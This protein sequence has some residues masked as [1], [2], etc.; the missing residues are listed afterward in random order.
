MGGLRSVRARYLTA[1]YALGYTGEAYF[2]S[3]NG[4]LKDLA[5]E[6]ATRVNFSE[7]AA[8]YG[9]GAETSLAHAMSVITQ[10]ADILY[11]QV[12]GDPAPTIVPVG[13]DQDPHI[14]LTRDVANGLRFFTVEDR[15]DVVSIRAKNA[16][17]GALEAVAKAFPGSKRYAGH[18]DVR[19][20]SH[21]D[22]AE[23]VRRS[24]A[25]L[26]RLRLL[27]AVGDLSHVHAR[28]SRGQDVVVGPRVP[29]R[30]CRAVGSGQEEGDGRADGRADHARGAATARRRTRTMHALRAEPVPHVR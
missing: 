27:P 10:V 14:R 24:R 21:N 4:A 12:A 8:I 28:A 18:V 22:A 20:M 26:R 2:Q 9:F 1:L 7:L 25:G 29:L 23:L 3:K 16:P 11:P 30:L 6:A 15:G 5:F 19:G 13:L 17:A